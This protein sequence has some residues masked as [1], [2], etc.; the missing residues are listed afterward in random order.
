MA[1]TA[2]WPEAGPRALRS[3]SRGGR[4]RAVAAARRHTRL[5]RWLRILLPLAGAVSA[6]VLVALTKLSLPAGIDLSVASLSVTRNSVI[7]DRPRLT[8]FD[9]D[10]REYSVAADRAVQALATPDVA[11]LE[12]ITATLTTPGHGITTITAESGDYDH[13]E[14]RLQLRGEIAIDSADGYTVR[15][16]EADIDFRGG[17]IVTPNPVTAKYQGSELAGQKL[18]VSEGGK[19]IR[20]HGGVSTLLMPPKRAE[21]APQTN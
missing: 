3:A 19:V 8:G 11:H 4:T 21:P 5:V 6:L 17:T 7:M 9:N 12:S 13:G 10:G 2:S 20:F 18:S 1:I 14:G 16:R 15:M